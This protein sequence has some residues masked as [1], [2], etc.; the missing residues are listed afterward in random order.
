MIVAIN[1]SDKNFQS[2][3]RLNKVTALLF[4]RVDKVVSYSPKD[5][6][7]SF[8]QDNKAIFC[9][10]TRGYGLWLWKPYFI[11]KT[12]VELE[13]GDYL[14]YSD[15]GS[16]FLRDVKDLILKMLDND[17][18]VFLS[19]I[20]LFEL[21]YTSRKVLEDFDGLS[22]E[23]TNQI[24]AGFILLRKSERSIN[25]ISQW[26]EACKQIEYL[27]GKGDAKESDFFIE[28]REDQSLLSVL[29]K[30]NKIEFYSDVTDYLISPHRYI[31]DSRQFFKLPEISKSRI[32]R[33]PF[34]LLYRRSN[35]VVYYIKFLFRKWIC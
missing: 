4:G 24:Q 6:D 11:L 19:Q 20:P 15:S 8:A 32:I 12:L 2:A 27:S 26:L 9:E 1:F 7:L 28:H 17:D 23:W 34:F 13:E 18:D 30:L 25:L 22:F 33:K 14:V 35:V 21:Q 29:S 16:I 31:Y 3:Q 10:Y 5:I